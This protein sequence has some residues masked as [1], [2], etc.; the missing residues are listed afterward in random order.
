MSEVISTD[1]LKERQKQLRRLGFDLPQKAHATLNR[2]NNM[3]YA[4]Q[5]E[6]EELTYGRDSLVKS[7]NNY[8]T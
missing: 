7:I 6:L 3:I 5:N 8:F 2:L 4:R 1:D